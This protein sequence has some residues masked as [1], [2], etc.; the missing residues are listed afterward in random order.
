[1]QMLDKSKDIQL[2]I[3]MSTNTDIILGTQKMQTD[4]GHPPAFHFTWFGQFL[5][6]VVITPGSNKYQIVPIQVF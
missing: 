5:N 3:S 6:L 4:H 1:M 2:I